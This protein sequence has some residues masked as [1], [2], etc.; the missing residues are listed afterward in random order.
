MASNEFFKIE[1]FN[2][3]TDDGQIQNNSL[4]HN[5]GSVT[6]PIGT[7]INATPTPPTG[8]GNVKLEDLR[9]SKIRRGSTS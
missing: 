6:G 4:T 3:Q 9:S 8:T 2:Y 1:L 5:I 7:A